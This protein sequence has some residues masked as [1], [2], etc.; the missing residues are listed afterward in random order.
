MNNTQITSIAPGRTCLFGDHQD[1]L[2]LPIIACAID[3]YIRISATANGSQQLVLDLPGINE[4]RTID[5]NTPIGE[6][7][8]GDHLLAALKVASKKGYVPKQGFD[9]TIQGNL[10]INAGVSSSSALTVAWMQF[11]MAASGDSR[12]INPA[13][14]AQLAY[15]AE[16]VEQNSPGGKMDQ[17][18][19]A[20]GNVLYLE[21]GEVLNYEVISTPIQGLIV[22]ESGIPKSTIGVLGHQKESALKAVWHMK[23][24]NSGFVLEKA[25]AADIEPNLQ[26]VPE[27]LRDYFVA[28]IKNHMVTQKALVELKKATS[29]LAIISGLMN[30][31]HAILRELLKITVPRIDDMIE[32]A[33]SAGAFGA[34]I[35]GSGM[36]G[37]ITAIA[38]E[39]KV[40]A[41]CNAIVNAGAKTAYPVS[42]DAGARLLPTKAD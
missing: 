7:Q 21:T 30:E 3:R 9:I 5:L 34:K 10:P 19:S 20:L 26:H 28:A 23:A 4:Q 27:D 15:E 37:S 24:A 13:E 35:V 17:Y 6:V 22:A 39:D 40:E 33:L 18:T 29:D 32:A 42:I 25:T 31:H 16:V 8:K 1:Y 38:P 14:L 2:G 41:V 12:D 11:L 36:G